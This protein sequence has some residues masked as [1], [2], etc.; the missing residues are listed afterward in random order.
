MSI[1]DINYFSEKVKDG[2]AK[3]LE[4]IEEHRSKLDKMIK[5]STDENREIYREVRD[6]SD[7]HT[8]RTLFYLDTERMLKKGNTQNDIINDFK[9]RLNKEKSLLDKFK[10]LYSDEHPMMVGTPLS[11]KRVEI[12]ELEKFMEEEIYTLI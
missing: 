1:L 6:R 2:R 4:F 10:E 8:Y 5:D 12:E 9:I 7:R 3:G 11:N